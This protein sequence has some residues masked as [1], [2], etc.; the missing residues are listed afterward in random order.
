M[1]LPDKAVGYVKGN[2]MGSL[3]LNLLN[4]IRCNI[5]RLLRLQLDS[6]HIEICLVLISSSAMWILTEYDLSYMTSMCSHV[7]KQEKNIGSVKAT[8]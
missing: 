2:E 1:Q 5:V 3:R 7:K 4:G 8:L 6:K